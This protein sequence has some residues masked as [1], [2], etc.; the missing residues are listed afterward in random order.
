MGLDIKAR[1]QFIY[2]AKEPINFESKDEVIARFIQTT[3]KITNIDTA[4]ENAAEVF[5][6]YTLLQELF[7]YESMQSITISK[8]EQKLMVNYTNEIERLKKHNYYNSQM[9]KYSLNIYNNQYQLLISHHNYD[10]NLTLIKNIEEISD[11]PFSMD[12]IYRMYIL[13]KTVELYQHVGYYISDKTLALL[14][15]LLFR[16]RNHTIYDPHLRSNRIITLMVQ[17]KNPAN[18]KKRKRTNRNKEIKY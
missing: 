12:Q 10:I 6:L 15:E 11:C 8:Q 5:A 3:N 18:I 17:K 4:N 7:L 16:I 2:P 9:L 13:R 1:H 14:E